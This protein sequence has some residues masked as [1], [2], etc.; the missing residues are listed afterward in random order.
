MDNQ[1]KNKLINFV[2]G[3]EYVSRPDNP[4]KIYLVKDL[5]TCHTVDD[6]CLILANLVDDDEND[7]TLLR[8]KDDFNFHLNSIIEW[9]NLDELPIA[10]EGLAQKY[11]SFIKKIGYLRYKGTEYWDGNETSAG[12]TGTNLK[13]LCEGKVSNKYGK[14][15]AEPLELSCPIIN[16]KGVPRSL[17]DFMRTNLRNAV[18]YAPTI[19]RK[20]LIPYSEIV[21]VNYLLAVHDNIEFLGPR[22]LNRLALNERIKKSHNLIY[23]SYVKNTFIEHSH[24]KSIHFEP[25]LTESIYSSNENNTKK[26]EGTI[27]EIFD[28]VDKFIIKGIGGLG[29][30]TTLRFFSNHLAK[31]GKLSPLFFSLK[32]YRSGINL[33]EQILFDANISIV[34]FENDLKNGS[35]FIL[36]LDGINEIINLNRRSDL[37]ND[38]KI[39][40]KK[41]NSCSFVISSR[42][43]P[44]IKQLDLPIFN[45]QPFDNDGIIEFIQKNFP[46]ISENLISNLNNSKRLL[47]VCSNPLL[48]SML[49]T[50]YQNEDLSK[51]NNEALIIRSFVNK[52]IERERLKNPSV[53]SVK[54]LQYLLDLGYYTRNNTLVLFSLNDTLTIL[55]KCSL[56]ISPGDD[57]IELIS[58]F[59]DM[60]FI[61][62]SNN[63]FSFTHELY[64]EY[65]AAE[66]LL[67]YERNIKEI[68]YIDYWRNPILMF[69]GLSHNRTEL[70]YSIAES[71][72][73]LAAECVVT[74]F[75]EEKEVE[76]AIIEKSIYFMNTFDDTIQYTKAVLALLK[77]KK[78]QE[79]KSGLPENKRDFGKL[80]K[81]RDELDGLSIIQT[82]IRELETDYLL[83]FIQLLLDK[84]ISYRNDIIRGLLDRDSEELRPIISEIGIALSKDLPNLNLLNLCNYITLIGKENL[85][86][87]VRSQLKEMHLG[88]IITATSENSS[89]LFIAN[90]LDWFND[91][92]SICTIFRN[93]PSDKTSVEKSL[94][95]ILDN[96]YPDIFDKYMLLNSASR[97]K[98]LLF[99]ISGLIYSVWNNLPIAQNEF[100]KYDVFSNKYLFT[101]I[102]QKNQNYI[103]LVHTLEISILKNYGPFSNLKYF[104][105]KS[106]DFEMQSSNNTD[107]ITLFVIIRNETFTAKWTG[108]D[109]IKYIGEGKFKKGDSIF[110]KIRDFDYKRG[111]FKTQL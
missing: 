67:F 98:N 64:Q 4:G 66:G 6:L 60:N 83:E 13:L 102:K 36:L 46:E 55:S 23:D 24:D 14:E 91:I 35:K 37:I 78:Y 99:Y 10:I 89:I 111:Y 7:D 90:I 94:P 61:S 50:V 21:I 34:E 32:E 63:N 69:S 42:N 18:H 2:K 45:I 15:N 76:N 107:S 8:L 87:K 101:L 41:Y 57:I 93:I 17:I 58:L 92:D 82:I 74:S 31:E 84:D 77:L 3:I 103:K 109:T 56:R 5:L 54:I 20:L 44:E 65:F 110:L 73:L 43:I 100:K 39:L 30:T 85:H 88:H 12:V 104:I 51:V 108:S 19:N 72:T 79:L 27:S 96:F 62:E 70:I 105:G 48:L 26:R 22:Y 86:I 38:F 28:S 106:Y 75:I 53:N 68:E 80:V 95:L 97:S 9:S 16:Y 59:K 52:S 40:L 49:C 81:P 71:D 29:K 25:R 47:R 11:E 1:L 33:I